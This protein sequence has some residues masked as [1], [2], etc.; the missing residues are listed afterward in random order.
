MPTIVSFE[1]QETEGAITIVATMSDG[2]TQNYPETNAGAPVAPTQTVQLAA[3]QSVL[4][5]ATA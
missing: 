4:V 1:T 3:G 2:T 5:E